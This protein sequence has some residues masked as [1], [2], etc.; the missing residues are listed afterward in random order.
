MT[1]PNKVLLNYGS[2][3][4]KPVNGKQI[5]IF[6]IGS[7]ESKKPEAYKASWYLSSNQELR[8]GTINLNSSDY[9]ENKRAYSSLIFFGGS[10]QL[11]GFEGT[12]H[13]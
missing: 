4:E 1:G 2:K 9:P 11:V 3:W 6:S 5:N 12:I 7:V 8:R 10:D 13:T